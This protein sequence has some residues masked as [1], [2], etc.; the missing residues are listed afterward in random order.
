MDKLIYEYIAPKKL[1]YE[2]YVRLEVPEYSQLKQADLEKIV[3]V[4]TAMSNY[5][6]TPIVWE[7]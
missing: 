5:Y 2:E 6:Y 7:T 1:T 3:N 4:Y